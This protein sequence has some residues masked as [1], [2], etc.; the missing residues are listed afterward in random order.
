MII[1]S[2]NLLL[3]TVTFQP[4]QRFF[5]LLPLKFTN[6]VFVT[7]C[8]GCLSPCTS[9]PASSHLYDWNMQNCVV[10]TDRVS[11]PV[12]RGTLWRPASSSTSGTESRSHTR[13]WAGPTTASG[14]STERLGFTE[15]QPLLRTSR[16]LT[17]AC[18]FYTSPVRP[19]HCSSLQQRQ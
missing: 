3:F 6:R 17:A 4:A 8:T 15:W 5:S 11:T 1:V 16:D 2:L 7:D 13:T 12:R 10:V 14:T 9:V 19:H 18:C